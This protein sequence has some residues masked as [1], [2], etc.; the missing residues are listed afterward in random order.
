MRLTKTGKFWHC[1]KIFHQPTRIEPSPWWRAGMP[2]SRPSSRGP[3]FNKS[4]VRTT[5]LW[6]YEVSN[7][8]PNGTVDFLS[9]L[10]WL[11]P[12]PVAYMQSSYAEVTTNAFKNERTQKFTP[13]ST[14]ISG[15]RATS[16]I[17]FMASWFE[18]EAELFLTWSAVAHVWPRRCTGRSWWSI[19]IDEHFSNKIVCRVVENTKS[20]IYWRNKSAS[21]RK[22]FKAPPRLAYVTNVKYVF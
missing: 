15:L 16:N 2:S 8:D 4:I 18:T 11:A 22:C 5:R 21:L 10:N 19:R 1:K 20:T 17:F 14:G 7:L 6:S 3:L 9:L 12:R 13:K